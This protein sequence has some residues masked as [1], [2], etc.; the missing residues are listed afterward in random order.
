C[1]SPL[2]PI[3]RLVRY[4]RRDATEP[5]PPTPWDR[6][7]ATVPS[8]PCAPSPA[9]NVRRVPAAELCTELRYPGRGR[10]AEAELARTALGRVRYK[11]RQT[12]YSPGGGDAAIGCTEARN[13]SHAAAGV[14]VARRPGA[15]RVRTG[16][17]FRRAV[18]FKGLTAVARDAMA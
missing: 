7:H 8:G 4:S 16:L 18:A 6:G 1:P 12:R 17:H 14:R 9:R 11:R 15:A 10:R 13:L 3:W 2:P 5:S